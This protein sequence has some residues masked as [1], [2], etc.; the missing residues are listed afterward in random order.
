MVKSLVTAAAL[1]ALCIVA[2]P[3]LV[4][5][6][7]RP[8]HY[9]A[10]S[11]GKPAPSWTLTDTKGSPRSLSDYAG[12]FV[13][14]E[15]TNN[16]CPFVKK[17]YRTGNMQ[18]LQK[19]AKEN[20]VVWLSVVSSA[21]GAPGYVTPE[22]G[23][24]IMKEQHSLATAELLDSDGKVGRAYGARCTP[25]MMIIDPKGT[26]IYSGGVDDKP[27]TDDD[28]LKTAHNYVK[29]ALQEALAGKPVTTSTSQPYGCG[30]KYAHETS[31]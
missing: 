6:S 26:L 23:N 22:E 24:K 10:A 27:T 15:W 29:A 7:L 1:A 20:G 30:I 25:D 31:L 12:K 16:Q 11:V 3:S 18:S 19:Y 8:V 5:A 28:D 21:P 9:A 17:H 4:S 13:V 2:V 14:L